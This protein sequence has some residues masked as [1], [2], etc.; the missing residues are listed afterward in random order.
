MWGLGGYAGA[1][2]Q[3]DLRTHELSVVTHQ[4]RRGEACSR[5]TQCRATGST[6]YIAEELLGRWSGGGAG[7]RVEVV[8]LHEVAGDGLL[9]GDE[10]PLELRGE[11]VAGPAGEGIRLK[12]AE[13]A[14]R[15]FGDL[16]ERTE[17]LQGEDG[18]AG[19]GV[20]VASPV[21][22]RLPAFGLE[23]VPTF[24]EPELRAGVAVVSMKARYSAQ[25]TAREARW[26]GA[27]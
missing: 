15:A 1:A 14:D 4:E 13:L 7:L 21:E 26:K 17:A 16:A 20:G 19:G 10:L 22:R 2:A 9:G 12:E 25:V 27:R 23:G 24:R 8:G 11:A 6:P 3:D 18:P 5:G